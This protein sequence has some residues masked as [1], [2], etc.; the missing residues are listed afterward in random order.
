MTSYD[1]I[2]YGTFFS[3]S[4]PYKL[5]TFKLLQKSKF[6]S[7]IWTQS[8]FLWL[9][10][11]DNKKITVFEK[12]ADFPDFSDFPENSDF[13]PFLSQISRSGN[14][15][16]VSK[17]NDIASATSYLSFTTNIEALPIFALEI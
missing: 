6:F 2:K 9:K 7:A 1:V 15:F 8:A 11:I 17:L 13:G 4:N 3:W 5:K 10:H 16:N 12:I 14:I